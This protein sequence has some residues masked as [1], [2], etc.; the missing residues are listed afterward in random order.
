MILT[1]L[2]FSWK[3]LYFS[4]LELFPECKRIHRNDQGK[5]RSCV[6]PQGKLSHVSIFCNNWNSAITTIPFHSTAC[7][8]LH[9]LHFLHAYDPSYKTQPDLT[10]A[11]QEV[12]CMQPRKTIITRNHVNNY[13]KRKDQRRFK[14]RPLYLAGPHMVLSR[15][16]WYLTHII[17]VTIL[18]R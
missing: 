7:F 13:T 2:L 3:Q 10:F 15:A 6:Q 9:C 17:L 4:T 5:H 1:L 8:F 12:E 18:Y 14:I 11:M 16:R